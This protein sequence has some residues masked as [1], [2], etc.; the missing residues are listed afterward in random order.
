VADPDTKRGLYRKYF[1]QRL[2]EQDRG[3][4]VVALTLVRREVVR[5]D[6]KALFAKKIRDVPAIP[7]PKHERCRYYVLDLDHDAFAEP[8]LQ[9]YAD[10]CAATYPALAVDLRAMLPAPSAGPARDDRGADRGSCGNCGHAGADHSA[11][12]T[13]C[14]IAECGCREYADPDACPSCGATP[15]SGEATA[16]REALR[17]A[18]EALNR[19]RTGL[20]AALNRIRNELRGRYWMRHEKDGGEAGSWGS[21]AYPEHTVET[22]RREI[23]WAFEAIGKI[24][25]DALRASGTIAD[26][27]VAAADR[28]LAASPSQPCENEFHADACDGS[29]QDCHPL[30][31]PSQPEKEEHRG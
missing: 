7:P 22:L 20:A 11:P 28:A 6:P 2:D 23:S 17:D 10:A 12:R 5:G 26:T 31:A 27:S 13:A 14:G 1:V 9:A 30:A 18:R 3:P 8:A 25:H 4:D 29:R 15:S 24:A 16:L 21:Y 19:D